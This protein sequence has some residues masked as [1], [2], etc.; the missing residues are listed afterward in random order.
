M[1]NKTTIKTT[2]IGNKKSES[3]NEK[4]NSKIFGKQNLKSFKYFSKSE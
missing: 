1:S 3:R 2:T 4:N